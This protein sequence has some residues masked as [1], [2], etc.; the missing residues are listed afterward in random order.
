MNDMTANTPLL[1]ALRIVFDGPPEPQAGRFVEVEDVNGKS[2]SAGTWH[3]RPDG[4]WEL[5]LD[6]LPAGGSQSEREAETWCRLAGK[7]I[8]ALDAIATWELGADLGED[9]HGIIG[10][11]EGSAAAIR[12]EYPSATA[13]SQP[14]ASGAEKR[15]TTD[16]H[17]S[18][19]RIMAG[20]QEAHAIAK[21][22]QP[23]ARV[24]MQGHAYV[25]EAEFKTLEARCAELER[26][27]AR[28]H[29]RLEIDR[30][31]VMP[32]GGN[33]LVRVEIPSADRPSM[34][35]GITARDTTIKMLDDSVAAL[36]ARLAE[37]RHLM[38][39]A[40]AVMRECGWQLA[41]TAEPQ[42]DGVLE[43]ACTEIEAD[44]AEALKANEQ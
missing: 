13:I 33:D 21:G 11:A 36:S 3:E 12:A 40:H 1:P 10:F 32:K 2:I 9:A 44:F 19:K 16:L 35:D 5:R 14:A 43:A 15:L 28:C 31:F 22:E 38:R 27:V 6:A 24:H 42:G 34:I 39:R 7:A 41:I 25:P 30:Q 8:D 18:G 4:L 23:A 17:P 37:M 26:E 29:G 20:L